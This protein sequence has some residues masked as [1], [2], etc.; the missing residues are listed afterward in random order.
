[1]S[2]HQQYQV[3]GI[4]LWV[5]TNCVHVKT[6]LCCYNSFYKPFLLQELFK[7]SSFSQCLCL[8]VSVTFILFK[9]ME[10]VYEFS[11]MMNVL[12]TE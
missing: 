1:V 11:V 3:S 8:V 6:A 12:I 5:R 7:H 2:D 10:C 9:C 4:G